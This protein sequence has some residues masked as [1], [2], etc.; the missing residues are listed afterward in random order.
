MRAIGRR[1]VVAQRSMQDPL[2]RLERRRCICGRGIVKVMVVAVAVAVTVAVV[3]VVRLKVEETAVKVEET[4]VK[5]E[6]T[7]VKGHA[8][9]TRQIQVGRSLLS[10]GSRL[11]R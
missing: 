5:V 11:L 10:Q 7:A 4:A 6:E 9:T 2:R 8:K 1:T 3:A